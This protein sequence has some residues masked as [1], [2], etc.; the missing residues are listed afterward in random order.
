MAPCEGQSA[1][2]EFV[3]GELKDGLDVGPIVEQLTLSLGEPCR[4][5]AQLA[6]IG[7]PV[8]RR[9]TVALVAQNCKKAKC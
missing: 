9:N 3:G 4:V 5:L 1:C 2:G 8:E 6:K 7:H